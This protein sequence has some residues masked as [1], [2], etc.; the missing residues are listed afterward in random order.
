MAL[1]FN[2][3]T[4]EEQSCNDPKLF[5][6]MLYYHYNKAAPLTKH[7]RSLR[8]KVSLTGSSFLLNPSDFFK[9]QTTDILFRVQY[10]KLAGRRDFM[11]FKMHGYKKLNTT[12][13]PDLI[14][15]SIKYNPLLDI[16][17]SEISFKYEESI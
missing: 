15:D 11:L 16:T 10:L 6:S 9:D 12:Y 7:N 8:S 17:P 4:L 14:Y 3:H 13:Y 1:F 2:I 5:I